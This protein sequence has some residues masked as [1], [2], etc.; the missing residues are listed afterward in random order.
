[1]NILII[2]GC[3]PPEPGTSARVHWDMATHLSQQNHRVWL[4]S[5]G[6]S[7]PLG[8]PYPKLKKTTVSRIN[9]NFQH[10]RIK[11][12]TYPDYNVLLRAYESADFGIRAI[13]Y[14]NRNIK[15]YDL[16][17]SC[18]WAFLGQFFILWLKRNKDA[19]L[20]MNVQ[21]LYPESFLCKIRSRFLRSLLSPLYMIDK[22]NARKSSHITVI[23]E[24]LKNVYVHHR[25][26]PEEKISILANWQDES[27]FLVPL[28][29][30]SE[31]LR[32]YELEDLAGWFV[33]M[34]LG[35][36][37]PVA[38]VENII[39]GFA[40]LK[41]QFCALIIAGS[42]SYKRKC[43]EL[44]KKLEEQD[45]YFIDVPP[46]LNSVVEL[47]S[48]SDVLLLP[49]HPEASASSI[50]SKLIDYMFS[51]RPVI[52]SAGADSETARVIMESGC[53]WITR[54][55]ESREW[56][57][58]MSLTRDMDRK[59][60][61]RKGEQGYGYAL[62]YF[63]REEGLNRLDEILQK[64]LSEKRQETYAGENTIMV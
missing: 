16:I 3:A 12:F 2:C 19:S 11:S 28:N 26:V 60:R 8:E 53:G 29:P 32:K 49:I 5:P 18:P 35:N 41:Y 38:G 14:I 23:S 55:N 7:R 56:S 20:I 31:I 43:Q 42:G 22:Y 10:V 27:A 17:Y 39:S 44:V 6:P 63:T 37:G 1:M 51:S 48:I 45:V 36:I 34:Y 59:T 62:R 52:S 30:K 21:D 64:V 15:D 47:Q 57:D 13:R 50:P 61:E 24:S 4:L 25:K 40:S 33:F 9:D 54:S 46:G 58:I